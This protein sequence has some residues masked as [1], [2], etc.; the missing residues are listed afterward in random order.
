M[1][2]RL[3]FPQLDVYDTIRRIGGLL[4]LW[5]SETPSPERL[6]IADFYLANPPLLHKAHMSLDVRKSFRELNVAKPEATFIRYPT[7]ILLFQKMD[8][9]Q[10]QAFRTLS[11]KGLIE[12]T[13]LDTGTVQ[14]SE[15]GRSLFIERF[16]PMFSENEIR[17]GKF[18]VDQFVPP[19]TPMTSVRQ[20]TGLRRLAR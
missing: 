5:G 13:A 7:P 9:V 15:N 11:G 20:G 18:L 8:E 4:S 3:W 17:I 12:I 16:L 14:P 6:F 2:G 19:T 1:I 10:R